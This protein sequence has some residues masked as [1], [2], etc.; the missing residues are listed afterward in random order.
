[1]RPVHGIQ[2]LPAKASSGADTALTL[3]K[4]FRAEIAQSH[5]L[6]Q[7]RRQTGGF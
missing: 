3:I 1:V 6:K 2:I 7:C 5:G 4:A